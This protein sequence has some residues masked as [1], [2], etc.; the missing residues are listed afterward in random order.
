MTTTIRP[1][2]VVTTCLKFGLKWTPMLVGKNY[3]KSLSHLQYSVVRV[4]IEVI[5]YTLV[6][7]VCMHILHV[8]LHCDWVSYPYNLG[9]ILVGLMHLIVWVWPWNH[10]GSWINKLDCID[11]NTVVQKTFSSAQLKHFLSYSF[12]Y[13]KDIWFWFWLVTHR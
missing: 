12:N 13:L 9:C 5:S 6:M 1:L 4:Q 7:C 10:M 2:L 8:Y 3:L 11:G